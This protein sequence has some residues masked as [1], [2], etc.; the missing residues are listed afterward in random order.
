MMWHY[1]MG[2]TWSTIIYHWPLKIK[3]NSIVPFSNVAQISQRQKLSKKR[4]FVDNSTKYFQIQSI[5]N[6]LKSTLNSLRWVRMYD[7]TYTKHIWYGLNVFYQR[8]TSIKI[9]Y[10]S[11]FIWN[12]F[13]FIFCS[14]SIVHLASGFSTFDQHIQKYFCSYCHFSRRT[15]RYFLLIIMLQG[16]HIKW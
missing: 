13:Y 10:H 12:H 6:V 9:S 2:Q 1:L 8:N 11:Q 16:N 4:F 14:K 3:V 7:K 15:C 5:E